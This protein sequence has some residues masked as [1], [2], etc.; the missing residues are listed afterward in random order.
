MT[1][2]LKPLLFKFWQ[3]T[4]PEAISTGLVSLQSQSY[5]VSF[6]LQSSDHH[7]AHDFFR[8]QPVKDAAVYFVRIVLHDWPEHEVH[9][10]MKN[11][12]A[13]AGPSS[14][15]VLFEFL[16]PHAC[17]NPENSFV[18]SPPVP[19]PLIPNTGPGKAEFLTMMDMQVCPSL[20]W[21]ASRT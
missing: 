2:P 7:P 5:Y 8:P 18:N 14:K 6:P 19:A 1:L 17:E 9:K 16:I 13:A 12:R 21:L 11:T 3:T 15:L 4:Y 10:I 20:L